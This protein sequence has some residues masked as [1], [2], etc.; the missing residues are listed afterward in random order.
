MQLQLLLLLMLLLLLLLAI[1]YLLI[2]ISQ[3]KDNKLIQFQISSL[4][5]AVPKKF[6]YQ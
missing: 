1:T 4:A 2:S 3:Q 5:N 6:V